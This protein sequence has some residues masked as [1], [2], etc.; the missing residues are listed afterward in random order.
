VLW[1][2]LVA[3]HPDEDISIRS[4]G[5][6]FILGAPEY[7]A[8]L[9]EMGDD[10]PLIMED[11]SVEGLQVVDDYTFQITLSAPD[12]LFLINGMVSITSPE[13]YEMLGDDFNNTPIGTGPYRFVEWLR[14]DRLTIEANP[15]YYIEGVPMNA[16]VYFINYGDE[17]TALLD[18]REDNID[19]LFSFPSGQRSAIIGEFGE[20][21]TEREGLHVRYWGFNMETGFLAENL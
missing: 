14:Q 19:F 20:Q 16:G 11:A 17:N 7:T 18:Y 6:E 9:E 15:D 12:R 21:F 10:A 8:A 13:G 5:L 1:N 3:L 2:Y 4:T